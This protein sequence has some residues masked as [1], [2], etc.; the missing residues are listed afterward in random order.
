TKGY[1]TTPLN[2]KRDTEDVSS[3]LDNGV[4]GCTSSMKRP[5]VYCSR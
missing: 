4:K 2:V 5:E 3:E 1:W